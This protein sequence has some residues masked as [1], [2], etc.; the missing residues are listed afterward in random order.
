MSIL[1]VCAGLLALLYAAL[2]IRVATMRGAKK[3]YLGDGGDKEMEAAVRAHANFMEYVPI[4]LILLFALVPYYGF[5][6]LAG[7]S[8]LLVV[9]RLLHAAGMFG[10]FRHGR[11]LGASL[12]LLVLV[13]SGLW[14][15]LLGLGIR[16]YGG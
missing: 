5:R 9:A 4:C 1:Y 16:L 6:T 11:A 13:V 12:T 2:S 8:A 15:G 14:L 7:L 10:Y 3:I